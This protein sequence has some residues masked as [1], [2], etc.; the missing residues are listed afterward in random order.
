M[1]PIKTTP[2]GRSDDKTFIGV[3]LGIVRIATVFALGTVRI[4]NGKGNRHKREHFADIRKRY[5]RHNRLDK[6]KK[7]RG[8]ERRWMTGQNHK[9]SK[10][11]VDIASQYTNPVICFEELEGIR[12]RARGSKRFNRMM[13]SWAFRQLVD[14]VKYKAERIGVEVIFVDPR[15]TSRMCSKCGHIS[16]SNRPNQANFRC[17]ACNF[18]VNADVNAAAN[19]AAVGLNASRQGAPDMPRLN[20]TGLE[21]PA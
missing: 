4:F 21:S 7:S 3:D 9:I 5:Q 14:F 11:I 18:Q 10:E 19:I 13:A 17:V 2:A 16:R 1:L 12:E 6:V 20:R 8:R 15:N